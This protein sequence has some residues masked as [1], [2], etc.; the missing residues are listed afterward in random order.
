VDSFVLFPFVFAVGSIVLS[1]Y[2]L[3][4]LP[5]VRLVHWLLGVLGGLAL[6]GLV[7]VLSGCAKE[8]VLPPALPDTPVVYQPPPS[9]DTPPP[10]MQDV[11]VSAVPLL[12]PT[13]EEL[14]APKPAPKKGSAPAPSPEKVIQDANAQALVTPSTMGYREG[15]T[16]TQRYPYVAGQ[17]YEIY[18]SPNHP[19]T[20]VLPLQEYLAVAPAMD[21]AESWDMSLG[22]MGSDATYQQFVQLRPVRAGLDFTTSFMFQSGL[23][24][25][26]RLRSF[27]KTSMVV[28][29][30]D[31]PRR[32]VNLQGAARPRGPGIRGRAKD[33]TPLVDPARLHT[34][35]AIEVTKGQPPWVP[36]SVYDDGT[37]TVIQFPE[38]LGHTR[39][40]APFAIDA[41]GKMNL[42][43]FI[44]YEVPGDDSK[45]TQ[46]VVQGLW[47]KLE[48]RGDGDMLVTIRR[49]TGKP[50]PYVPV[51]GTTSGTPAPAPGQQPPG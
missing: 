31:M 27:A 30:W 47:P 5:P 33:A 48:L 13:S 11:P 16:V 17:L 1:V 6:V 7:L 24:I 9:G 8:E 38:G 37:K 45:G 35:Y 22:E 26:C 28:V 18:S 15:R 51:S 36:L 39:A 23:I 10:V 49:Q 29:M 14:T 42:V 19:T 44:P 21:T 4:S 46:Y 20:I 41:E 3:C 12:T 2:V 32:P 25:S 50:A 43:Q 34:A 40:P